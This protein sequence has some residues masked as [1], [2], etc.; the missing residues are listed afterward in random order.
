MRAAVSLAGLLSLAACNLGAPPGPLARE[1]QSVEAG[2]ATHAR[3]DIEMSGGELAIQSGA[4]GLFA[5]EFEFNRPSLKP[6]VAYSV[7]G[8]AGRLKVSQGSVSGSYENT[9]RVE[10]DER[11]P[12][13]LHITLTAGDAELVLGRLTLESLAIQLGAGDLKVDLRGMPARS[14]P[15]SINAGAGDT[16]IQLPAS[17]NISARTFGLIGDANVSGLEQRD[18]RWVN[19]RAPASP[20]RID[21]QIQHAIGDLTLAAE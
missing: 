16:T 8:T 6:V 1:Q 12:L 9:W 4:T 5:G 18:G 14:Y 17:A 13:E 20:V 3:V 19:A 15:V 21:L 7:D 2:D 11:L 10:L